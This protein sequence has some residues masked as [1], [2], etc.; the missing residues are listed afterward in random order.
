LKEFIQENEKMSKEFGFTGE[1]IDAND[2]VYLRNRYYN[3]ELGTFLS[4][5]PYEGDFNDPMSLNRYAYV[6]G[7]PVNLTDPSGLCAVDDADCLTYVRGTEAAFG[8]QVLSNQ[9]SSLSQPEYQNYCL[10]FAEELGLPQLANKLDWAA[11][12]VLDIYRAFAIFDRAYRQPG[13]TNYSQWTAHNNP[14]RVVKLPEI[15]NYPT[16]DARTYYGVRTI[17]VG[18]NNWSGRD[19]QERTWLILHEFGH[20]L[21]EDQVGLNRLA[22]LYQ[23]SW[24]AQPTRYA[25][26]SGQEFLI[27]AITGAIWNAGYSAIRDFDSTAGGRYLANVRDIYARTITYATPTPPPQTTPVPGTP[28]QQYTTG[29]IQDIVLEEWVKDCVLNPNDECRTDWIT[30]YPG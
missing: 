19:R 9:Q 10:E 6:R 18:S 24:S 25:G 26:A 7:N 16:F 4:M 13:L 30:P 28:P 11:D 5:D 3:P 27:E 15:P 22:T 1:S 17:A 14:I 29:L 21:S 8:V 20:I 12:E 2:L 23:A